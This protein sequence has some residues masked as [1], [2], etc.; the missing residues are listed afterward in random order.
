MAAEAVAALWLDAVWLDAVW[1]DDDE[2]GLDA[3]LSLNGAGVLAGMPVDRAT[4][5]WT[6]TSPEPIDPVEAGT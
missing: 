5:P 4:S 1:L 2:G 3:M 6:G